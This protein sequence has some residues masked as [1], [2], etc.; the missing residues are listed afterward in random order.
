MFAWTNGRRK[1]QEWCAEA[2]I[3]GASPACTKQFA[4]QQHI[5]AEQEIVSTSRGRVRLYARSALQLASR[6]A[7]R[8]R[9]G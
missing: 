6:L 1:E 3:S 8:K 2:V 9:L 4:R 7:M 5:S